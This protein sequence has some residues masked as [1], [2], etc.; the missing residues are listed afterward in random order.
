MAYRYGDQ[1]DYTEYFQSEASLDL[2]PLELYCHL[3]DSAVRHFIFVPVEGLNYYIGYVKTI[4]VLLARMGQKVTFFSESG[5]VR[6]PEGGSADDKEV[7][8]VAFERSREADHTYRYHLQLLPVIVRLDENGH[9]VMFAE[10]LRQ[11]VDCS[12]MPTIVVASNPGI[13]TWPKIKNV[14]YVIPDICDPLNPEK[15]TGGIDDIKD[16]VS[17]MLEYADDVFLSGSLFEEFKA[18]YP[19]KLHEAFPA[20]VG[21]KHAFL[22]TELDFTENYISSESM[23]RNVFEIWKL[24]EE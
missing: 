21:G 20:W 15:Y 8:R 12:E 7:A 14:R 19:K 9:K 6:I 18:R 10:T 11:C 3:K 5:T 4:A 23:I 24:T 16:Y 13:L 1:E 2:L 17:S 22:D